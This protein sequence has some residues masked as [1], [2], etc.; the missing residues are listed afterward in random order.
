MLNVGIYFP[1]IPVGIG[2][3]LI[4]LTCLTYIYQYFYTHPFYS[5]HYSVLKNI[6]NNKKYENK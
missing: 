6:V 2:K 5:S 4:N 3:D 1:R